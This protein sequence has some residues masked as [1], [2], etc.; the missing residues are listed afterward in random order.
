MTDLQLVPP[1]KKTVVESIIEQ[2]IEKIKDGTL[3]TG[4]KL[5]SERQLIDMLHVS[6]SSV[7]EALQ[8]LSAMDLIE[9][10]PGDGTFVKELKPQFYL[11]LDIQSLSSVLQKQMYRH[12]NQARLVLESGIA[13]LAATQINPETRQSIVEAL[14]AYEAGATAI[15]DETGWPGHN[16]VHQAIA[17]ATGNPILGQ[18]LDSLLEH[19]PQSLRRKTILLGTPEQ[20]AQRVAEEK[21]IHTQLCHAVMKGDAN[22]ACEWI[23]HHAE[24]EE[25]LINSYNSESEG[26]AST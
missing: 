22:M 19:I 5:P 8:G 25:Q 6:R 12:M 13:E 16:R 24:H 11:N 15:S 10:R 20:V 21:H 26:D 23:G 14:Q 17:E 2:L 3:Q 4:A 9:I 18:I 7:R 1:R